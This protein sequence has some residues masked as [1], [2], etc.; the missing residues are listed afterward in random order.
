MY[1][2]IDETSTVYKTDVITDEMKEL[3]EED[4][5]NVFVL[6]IENMKMM[7]INDVEILG[8]KP[9]WVPIP[10][11]T[12]PFVKLDL[13]KMKLVPNSYYHLSFKNGK[14]L[15]AYYY[16]QGS[17]KVPGF[18]FNYVDGGWWVSADSIENLVDIKRIE[19][20]W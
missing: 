10:I 5:P 17:N 15:T 19:M 20:T 16:L 4:H 8:H 14:E 11:Y 12:P 13:S 1:I 18:G 2:F 6:D 9:L 7:Y 3:L